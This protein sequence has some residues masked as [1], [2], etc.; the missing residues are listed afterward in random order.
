MIK[1]IRGP[2]QKTLWKVALSLGQNKLWKGNYTKN[3][4][5]Q[6]IFRFEKTQMFDLQVC[7][8][9]SLV[10]LI[11]KFTINS[12][13]KVAECTQCHLFTCL[14]SSIYNSSQD[15]MMILQRRRGL[16]IPV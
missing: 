16:W 3:N 6:F 10:F 4:K 2:L 9:T 1:N 11:G 7:L 12:T 5:K 14:D 15:Q 13:L 8:K